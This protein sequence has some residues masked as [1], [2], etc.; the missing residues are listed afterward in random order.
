MTD[1]STLPPRHVFVCGLHRSGTSLLARL[2]ASHDDVSA[3]HA[4]DV[5]EGEGV[6]LQGAIPHTARHGVP[7]A[8][9]FDDAQHLTEE[10]P[11]N[12]ME[13]RHRLEA[14]WGPRFDPDASW[15]LEKSPVNLLRM[16][17]YQ[18]LFPM[19]HFIIITRHPA[20]VAQATAKWSEA[21]LDR[22]IAHWCAA[23]ELAL[24]DLPWLHAALVVRYEDLC[25]DPRAAMAQVAAFLTLTPAL[26]PAE[27]IKDDNT[28]C[29]ALPGP[30]PAPAARLGYDTGFRPKTPLPEDLICRH[31]LKSVRHAVLSVARDQAV[32]VA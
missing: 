9:A 5:P 17:L 28:R 6:Y 4:P 20:A 32:Q 10:H 13:T 3:L 22:L 12:R 26:D 29:A 19:A 27:R 8:F 31:P 7:G 21:P 1:P 18:Q 16:R 14:D 2:I 24:S 23:H 30:V 11:L 25:A 15:R